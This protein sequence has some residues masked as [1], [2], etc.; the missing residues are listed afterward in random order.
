MVLAFVAVWNRW[1]DPVFYGLL[2]TV[3]VVT[4]IPFE[5]LRLG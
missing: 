1:L 3:V 4:W 2:E 5:A